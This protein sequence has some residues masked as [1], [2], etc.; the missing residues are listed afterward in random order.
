MV[1]F[2]G[3][4]FTRKGFERFNAARTG[5]AGEGLTEP[6]LYLR[7][8]QMKTNPFKGVGSADEL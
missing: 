2:F 5:T 7:Y 1:F 8:A 6:N 3:M 4:V